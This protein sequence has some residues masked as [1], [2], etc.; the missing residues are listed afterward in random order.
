MNETSFNFDE[1]RMIYETMEKLVNIPYRLEGSLILVN[2]FGDRF[3][4]FWWNED[5]HWMVKP[6][7]MEDR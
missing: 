2:R 5:I 4:E 6:I 1:V 3:A 7:P